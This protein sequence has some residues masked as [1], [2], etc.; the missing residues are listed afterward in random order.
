MSLSKETLRTR[1]H[2]LVWEKSNGF[3]SH[4]LKQEQKERPFTVHLMSEPFKLR[5]GKCDFLR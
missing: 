2:S 5:L 3:P 4:L 1:L